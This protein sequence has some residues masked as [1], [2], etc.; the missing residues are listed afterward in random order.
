M[1]SITQISVILLGPS[2]QA[3]S[4]VS[5]HIKQL[6]GSSL[7]QNIKLLHFQVGSEGRDESVLNKLSRFILSPFNFL[8]CLL[9]N[10]HAI[11]HIN[12]S[13]EPKS[14]WRDMVYLLIA[15]M[16]KH[17]TI[18]QIHGGALP[19]DFFKGSRF[20]TSLLRRILICAD[21][22]VLLAQVELTAYHAFA[23]QI[24][25]AVIANAIETDVLTN[26]PLKN[27]PTHPLHISFVGRLATAK[28]IFTILDAAALLLQ[29]QRD[30]L[31]TIAGSGSEET[32]MR[33]RAT[34][35]NLGEHIQFMGAVF[36]QAKDQLWQQTHVFAFPTIHREGLPYALLEAMAAGAVPI[37]TR[38]GA[39]P[40]VMQDGV[41]GLFVEPNNPQALAQAIIKLDDDR[42]L[43]H[44]MAE[45]GR[46]RILDGYGV[47]RL[48][49]DFQDLYSELAG[50]V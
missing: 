22:V 18:Y 15:K 31:L 1:N 7:S 20:L 28:G 46:Q 19:Q 49:S 4:G 48:A 34:E 44:K 33:T 38:V 11:V 5:T 25:L 8:I 39:I 2:L 14:Y 43:R 35:L 40:D 23:P 29:A 9:R 45:A 27:K 50:E 42:T 3:V 30:F 36:D 26:V 17:K 24:R 37:T 12:T 16:L 32:N 13:L 10:R 21:R 6:T 47:D 41:H